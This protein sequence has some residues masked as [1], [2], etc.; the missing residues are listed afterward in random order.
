M[1]AILERL[2]SIEE[3]K[4]LEEISEKM[5]EKGDITLKD[6]Y[7][8]ILSVKK[9]GSLRKLISMLPFSFAIDDKVLGKLDDKILDK[10]LAILNSM[11]ME[12]L[13]KPNIIDKSRMKRIAMGSGTTVKDVE[14]LLN[15]YKATKSMLRKIR[16]NK[17]LLQRLAE[18]FE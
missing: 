12:E 16:K 18:R 15:H 3:S 11:T 8:Q 1:E 10:W 4:K 2:K 14:E 5:L 9:M 13:E 17:K 7:Y 6:L